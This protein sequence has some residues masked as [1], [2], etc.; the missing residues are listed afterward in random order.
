MIIGIGKPD[1]DPMP[2]GC[3]F[4]IALSVDELHDFAGERGILD[5][6]FGLH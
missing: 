3:T 2:T 5:G 4:H 6:A 1:P